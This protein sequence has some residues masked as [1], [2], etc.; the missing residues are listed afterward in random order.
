MGLSTVQWLKRALEESEIGARKDYY[1]SIREGYRSFIAHRC[2][3]NRPRFL[4]VVVYAEGGRRS[5]IIIPEEEGGRGWRRMREVL[6]EL[7]QVVR[8]RVGSGGNVQRRQWREVAHAKSY[9]EALTPL[10]TFAPRNGAG[11]GGYDGEESQV[12]QGFFREK[13]CE[14]D[15]REVHCIGEGGAVVVGEFAEGSGQVVEYCQGWYEDG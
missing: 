1:S 10:V 12:P 11:G 8:C 15:V 6:R 3:N 4:E 13:E 5:F 9:K 7:T 2:S 14:R